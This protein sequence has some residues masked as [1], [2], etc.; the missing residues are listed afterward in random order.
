MV[1]TLACACKPWLVDTASPF[2]LFALSVWP[3]VPVAFACGRFII[4]S[5][6]EVASVVLACH[7]DVSVLHRAPNP[8]GVLYA[9]YLSGFCVLLCCV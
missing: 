6:C 4:D 2:V 9:V 7:V 5:S 8:A 1:V 3:F